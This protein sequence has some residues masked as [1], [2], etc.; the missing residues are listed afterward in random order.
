MKI[1]ITGKGG[2]GKTTLAAGLA[3][4]FTENNKNVLVID[5]DPDSNLAATLGF[6]E[7]ENIIPISQM[8]ELITERAG[9]QD[10]FFKMNPKVDDI[11]D[12]YCSEHRGIKLLVMGSIKKA[13]S[14]CYCPENALIKALITHLLIGR[15][16]VLI[17]DM[18][19]GI[20]HLG[21]GTSGNVDAL[22]VVV[23]PSKRSI[24]TAFRIKQMTDDL[25]MKKVLIVGNKIRSDEEIEFIKK[26]TNSLDILGFIRYNPE[27]IDSIDTESISIY[28]EIGNRLVEKLAQEQ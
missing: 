5:A 27:L 23:E 22:L 4:A 15:D 26:E 21:R 6:P 14:G 25:K 2:V 17:M 19:A 12:T 9:V 10:G 16:D 3:L 18:E 8:K 24:E 28:K 20:E 13:G 1:A 11:P 7:P